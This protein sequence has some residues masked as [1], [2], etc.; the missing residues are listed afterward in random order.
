[1]S[2]T[3]A[4][5]GVVVIWGPLGA[6]VKQE[7]AGSEGTRHR[8]EG[9]VN[10]TEGSHPLHA[11]TRSSRAPAESWGLTAPSTRPGPGGVHSQCGVR[12]G[13]I[14][15]ARGTGG[16]GCPREVPPGGAARR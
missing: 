10:G 9:W 11:L 7:K 4:L 12:R 1:M 3:R 15:D 13:Q 8:K 16:G 2:P 14:R 6:A 5:L